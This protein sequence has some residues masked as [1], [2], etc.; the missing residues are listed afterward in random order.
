M[1]IYIHFSLNRIIL[2]SFFILRLFIVY[3][4]SNISFFG[5]YYVIPLFILFV[6]L[7]QLNLLGLIP[8]SF[9]VTSQLEVTL[10][11]AVTFFVGC[12]LLLIVKRGF[13]YF[14]LFLPP[15]APDA[16]IPFLCLIEL[17][18]YSARVISLS[19]RLF[20][21][22]MAGHSLLKILVLFAFAIFSDCTPAFF[23][24]DLLPICIVV[25]VTFL[26]VGVAFIQAYVFL[27]LI[28]VYLR[29]LYF[30]HYC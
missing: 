14:L 20:A 19:V 25:A 8:I 28:N 15:G 9:T 30:S 23:I 21:N 11:L 22:I 6:F 1:Y 10:A 24:C 17:V 29:D 26:E 13:Y 18:S 12:N 16:I 3:L 27:V 2:Y 4:K 7:L 5:Q